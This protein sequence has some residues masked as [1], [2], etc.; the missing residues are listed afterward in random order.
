[1]YVYTHTFGEP[2]GTFGEEKR[3]LEVLELQA[4]VSCLTGAGN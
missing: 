1:M 2:L 3:T 4:V